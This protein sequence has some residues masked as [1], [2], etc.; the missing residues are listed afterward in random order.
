MNWCLKRL[1]INAMPF[2]LIPDTFFYI[3]GLFTATI[4]KFTTEK[5]EGASP[6]PLAIVS[7]CVSC[8]C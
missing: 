7:Y 5:D 8:Y 6:T 2:P 4:L 3:M 1:R